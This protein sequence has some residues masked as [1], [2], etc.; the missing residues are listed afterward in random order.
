MSFINRERRLAIA[1]TDA[2]TTESAALR[3]RLTTSETLLAELARTLL[4]MV[5]FRFALDADTTES[6]AL[7]AR[8][9]CSATTDAVLATSFAFRERT[10]LIADTEALITAR[11]A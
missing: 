7:R 6:A 4:P 1:A 3:A 11:T 9:I 10:A 2:D 5:R 8:L